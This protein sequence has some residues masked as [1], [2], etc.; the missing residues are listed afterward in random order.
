MAEEKKID[1]IYQLDVDAIK[2]LQT[3][4]G[5]KADGM[6]GKKTIAALQ[7]MLNE[8]VDAKLT[9]DGIIGPK[10]IKALQKYLGVKEDGIFGPDTLNALQLDTMK[11]EATGEREV[12]T[13][14]GLDAVFE[15]YMKKNGIK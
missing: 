8:K 1:S 14:A 10:T 4:L 12:T 15:E 3:K 2:A 6:I 7:E 11:N 13:G 9:A 5:V